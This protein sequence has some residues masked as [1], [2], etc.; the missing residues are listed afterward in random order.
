M[1]RT[2]ITLS[3]ILAVGLAAYVVSHLHAQNGGIQQVNAAAPAATRV[4]VINLAGVVKQ[5]KKWEAFEDNYKNAAKEYEKAFEKKRDALVELKKAFDTTVENDKREQLQAQMKQVEREGQDLSEQAKK[6]LGKYREDNCVQ[7]YKEVQAATERY[8]RA[9]LIG[10]VLHY[11]DAVT[12][13]EIYHPMNVMHKLQTQSCMP[14]YI[15][16][17]MDI[18]NHVAMMLNQGLGM[19]GNG[20]R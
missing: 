1:K 18:T 4:A 17:E 13:A 9:H 2:A 16:P 5:Y 11:A 10:L 6:Q 8:A 3:S 15:D 19:Q 14:M 20:Q 7:I 12:P